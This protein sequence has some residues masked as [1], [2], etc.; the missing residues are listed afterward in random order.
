MAVGELEG[1]T[2]A[3][4]G[5]P[6]GTLRVWD[7]EA[8]APIGDPLTGHHSEITAV[9]V[10]ERIAVSASIDGLRV[11][12]LAAGAPIG[13]PLT[14]HEQ[15]VVPWVPAAGTI[16]MG[17]DMMSY[18]GGLTVSLQVDAGLIPDPDTIIVDYQREVETLRKLARNQTAARR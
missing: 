16:G 11:W 18:N 14:G 1:R 4:S 8:G 7:L 12:D 6:E 9:A 13:D 5:C 17:I 3:V 10:G 2:I 15:G